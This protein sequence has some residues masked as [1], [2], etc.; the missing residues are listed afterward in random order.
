LLG[1]DDLASAFQ[2]GSI[3]VFRLAPQDYHRYHFPIN[4]VLLETHVIDG[5][6]YTVN[7]IAVNKVDVFTVN[8]RTVSILDSPEFGKVPCLT[9]HSKLDI[10]FI[11]T[12]LQVA[13]VCVGA[14]LVGSIV[15]TH[16]LQQ[17]FTKGDEFGF[18]QFGGSTTILLF[19]SG[20]IEYD[21]DLLQHS[22]S[23]VEVLLKMGERVGRA[24]P[25]GGEL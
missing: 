21:A 6:L 12:L 11:L 5:P 24:L 1:G 25:P 4:G 3:A 8:Q 17:P 16:Q 13:F 22:G 19:Q 2:G 14:T 7:P 23:S 15:H 20:R 18:F 9:L 10:G